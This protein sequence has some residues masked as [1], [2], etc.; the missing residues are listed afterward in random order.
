[1][2]TVIQQ[3]CVSGQN[4]GG[5]SIVIIYEDPAFINNLVNIYDGFEMVGLAPNNTLEI[6]LQGINVIDTQGG[7]IGFLAWEG[8]AANPNNETLSVNENLLSNPPLNP[9]DNVFNGTNSFTGATNLYNM[10]LDYYD[11]SAYVTP[12]DT[13]LDVMLTSHQDVVFINNIVVV[14]SSELPDASITVNPNVQG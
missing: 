10:D 12:G 8:D 13:T 14:L 3:Y 2:N 5:W 11:I 1:L 4:F 6:Q 7:K 9:S